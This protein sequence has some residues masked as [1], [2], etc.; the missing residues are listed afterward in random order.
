L[1]GRLVGV[2]ACDARRKHGPAE[3][4]LNGPQ[5]VSATCESPGCISSAVKLAHAKC[6]VCGLVLCSSCWGYGD[7]SHG[8]KFLGGSTERRKA[9]RAGLG[10]GGVRV[11]LRNE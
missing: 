1:G 6:S 5:N 3:F 4:R 9:R 11:V 2:Q 8:L 10:R 7:S